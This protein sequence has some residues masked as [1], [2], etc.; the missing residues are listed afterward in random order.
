MKTILGYQDVS[1][2]VEEVFQ[3]LGKA[4]VNEHKAL[5]KEKKKEIL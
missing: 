1:E 3:T 4:L 2:I 5:Y